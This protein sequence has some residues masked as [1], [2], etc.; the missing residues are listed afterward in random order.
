MLSYYKIHAPDGELEKH[1]NLSVWANSMV[2]GRDEASDCRNFEDYSPGWY[3][4][5]RIRC[6]EGINSKGTGFFVSTIFLGM[7]HQVIPSGKP[8]IF[9]TMVKYGM[10]DNIA[11][12]DEDY[13]IVRYSTL[14]EAIRGHNAILDMVT[15][16]GAANW[17]NKARKVRL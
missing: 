1:A 16:T 3:G 4:W 9:E 11:E 8:L 13:D 10:G 17:V 7:D 6:D 15:A 12:G 2:S 14:E 5:A